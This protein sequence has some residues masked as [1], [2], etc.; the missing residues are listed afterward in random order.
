MHLQSNR[1]KKGNANG[2]RRDFLD[3]MPSVFGFVLYL[4]D[5]GWERIVIKISRDSKGDIHNSCVPPRVR[6]GEH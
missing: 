6:V 3:E 5:G 4:T 2:K 1:R